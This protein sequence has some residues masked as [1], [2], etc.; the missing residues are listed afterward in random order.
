MAYLPP[1]F[2]VPRAR[3]RKVRLLFIPSESRPRGGEAKDLRLLFR[4]G[5]P[6]TSG[7][8]VNGQDAA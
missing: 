4:R 6:E 5:P 1:V 2:S 8:P 7:L 3:I